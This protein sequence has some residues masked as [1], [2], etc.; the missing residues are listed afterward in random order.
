MKPEILPFCAYGFMSTYLQIIHHTVPSLH[1]PAYVEPAT[2]LNE[3]K[4]FMQKCHFSHILTS[5]MAVNIL[6]KFKDF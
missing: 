5:K 1:L 3:F 4:Y 2:V 6:S